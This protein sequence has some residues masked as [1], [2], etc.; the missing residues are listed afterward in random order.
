MNY[1][2]IIKVSLISIVSIVGVGIVGVAG[3]VTLVNPNRFKPLIEKAAHEATGRKLTLAGDISWTVYPNLGLKLND[4]SLS[5]ESGFSPA[6]MLQVKS[7]DIAVGLFPL[8][9][10]HLVVKN[11][12][13]DGLTMSLTQQNGKNNWT[14]TPVSEPSA[15]SGTGGGES[16]PI[17]V[18]LSGMKLSN[19]TVSYDDYDAKVHQ[20][21]KQANLMVDSGFGGGIEYDSKA[22]L[23]DLSKVK[24]NYND[25]AIGEMTF[26]AANFSNPKFSGD[27]KI[28]K[29]AANKL[30]NDLN[31]ATK[32]RKGKSILNNITFDGKV[33]GTKQNLELDNFSFN[34]SDALKG[35]VNLVA[36]S[37]DKSPNFSGDINLSE[38]DLKALMNQSPVQVR[39][40]ENN[41]L[42]KNRAA[43]SAK[44][45]GDMNNLRLNGYHFKLADIMQA[46]GNLQ[47]KNFKNP[48]IAGDVSLPE[49]NLNQVLDSLNIAIKERKDKPLLNKFAFSSKFNGGLNSMTLNGYSF[50]AGGLVGGSGNSVQIQ[51]FSNPSVVG[52]INLPEFNLNQTLDGL[53]IATADRKN[54]P[55]LNKFAFHSKFKGDMNNMAL[56]GYSFKA[57]G[58]FAGSGNGVQVQNFANPKISGDINLP[59]FSAN[60]VMQQMGMTPP[61]IPN[62]A[63][64]NQVA[65]RTNFA[66][67]QTAMNLSQMLLKVSNTNISGNVNVTSFKPLAVTENITIDALD[68]S[69]FSDVNGFKVPLKNIQIQGNSSIAANG[70]MSTLNGRQSVQVGNVTLLGFS[71][72][73][74]VHYMDRTISAS[75]PNG[76]VLRQLGNAVQINQAMDKVKAEVVK[77]TS[78]GPKDYSK[79]TDLGSFV[80]VAVI[81]NGLVNP[82]AFKLSGPS[83]SANGGG[84]VNLA[85]KTLNYNVS[86]QLLVSGINPVFKKLTFPA[87][88]K[89]SFKDPSLSVDWGSITQQLIKYAITNGGDQIK[90]AVSQGINQAVG[91]QI[92]QSVGQQGG[93]QVIDG[94]SKAVTGVI[95]NIF[96]K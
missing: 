43:F 73:E 86:S 60:Q 24:F 80:T 52:D 78:P 46:S 25:N 83:L 32:E 66:G 65:L 1:K 45:S 47:V 53:N 27:F 40:L 84:S 6:N 28:T 5:N 7:A 54:K 29:L 89:G 74:Q 85:T 34:L 37:L 23:I 68:V 92:R 96:G 9:Y 26:T 77:A 51:N 15:A 62:K 18:S 87:T 76:D 38:M 19:M 41:K 63:R 71:V 4:V 49:F 21:I 8:L 2:K 13:V 94:A 55:L 10:N 72:D 59:T 57:G 22:E 56:S 3:V 39:E 48:A 75:N 95:Q 69:D 20:S 35:K 44:F 61:D 33:S 64:L 81:K 12:V 79:K 90:N 31:I 11:L 17:H 93:D 36:K 30:L 42:L 88:I 16:Q 70:E 67:S 58:I 14:F 82:S 50:K 91:N